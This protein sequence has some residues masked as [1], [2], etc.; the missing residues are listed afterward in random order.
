MVNYYET[1][2][3]FTSCT[4]IISFSFFLPPYTEC[5]FGGSDVTT[6]WSS[7][8]RIS[9]SVVFCWLEFPIVFFFDIRILITSL[10]FSNSS[11]KEDSDMLCRQS[12]LIQWRRNLFTSSHLKIFGLRISAG[13]REREILGYSTCE[14]PPSTPP[15]RLEED[16]RVCLINLNKGEDDEGVFKILQYSEMEFNCVRKITEGLFRKYST[17]WQHKCE[18][19]I[20]VLKIWYSFAGGPLNF[21]SRASTCR[22]YM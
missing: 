8:D 9:S 21:E 18:S 20:T 13:F 4:V 16:G 3:L 5:L 15:S 6:L 22:A 12:I 10:V 17:L 14:V 2:V 11:R 19:P 7:A 1:S